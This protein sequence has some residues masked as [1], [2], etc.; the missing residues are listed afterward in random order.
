MRYVRCKCRNREGWT[1]DSFQDCQGCPDCKTTFASHPD[2]HRPL[3]P[4]DWETVYNERTGKPYKRCK[5]CHEVDEESYKESNI[6]D[7]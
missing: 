2:N 7:I 1:S 5:N 4:H 6:K 3:Q